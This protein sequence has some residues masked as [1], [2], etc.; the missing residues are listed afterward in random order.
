MSVLTLL[1]GIALGWAMAGASAIVITA[2]GIPRLQEAEN[3]VKAAC[4][5]PE[6]KILALQCDATDRLAVEKT[7][8]KMKE[9]IGH[10]DV[11][12]SNVG[13]LSHAEDFLTI[14]KKT[15]EDWMSDIDVNLKA[16][17]LA[18]YYYLNTFTT[19]DADA[20]GTIISI[21]SNA[22]LVTIPGMV[23]NIH[24]SIL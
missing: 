24:L 14:G 3:E 11:L 16:T 15:V 5:N 20:T 9:E 23:S 6:S 13:H 1:Q 22:A 12:I 4:S 18:T 2:R 7:F 8:A 17:Y 19:N 10:I 21:T